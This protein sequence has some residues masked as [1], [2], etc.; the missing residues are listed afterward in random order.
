MALFSGHA[1][2]GVGQAAIQLAKHLGLVIYVTVGTEDKRRL[3]IEQYNIPKEHIFHS[4][5]AS[6]VKGISR[7][8]GGR[9]IDC[10]LNSLPGELLRASWDCTA[11][12]ETFVGATSPTTCASTCGPSVKVLPLRLSTAISFTKKTRRRFTKFLTRHSSLSSRAS[13]VLRACG[14]VSDQSSWGGI[15]NHATGQASW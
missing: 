12:F 6:L 4:R 2:G 15:P 5:D 9:G 14:R 10:V 7:I 3:I 13:L 8:T 11:T 1:A